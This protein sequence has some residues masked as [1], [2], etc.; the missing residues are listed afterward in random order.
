[1]IT[2]YFLPMGNVAVCDRAGQ[3]SELQKSYVELYC[4]FL[5]SKGYKPEGAIFY[6]PNGEKARAFKTEHGWNWEV[7]KGG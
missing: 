6:L 1:M 2:V 3:M 5:E 7:R 4:E